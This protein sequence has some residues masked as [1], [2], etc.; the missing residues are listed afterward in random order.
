MNVL[1]IPQKNPPKT[2][3]RVSLRKRATAFKKSFLT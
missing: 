2:K 3:E 1:I